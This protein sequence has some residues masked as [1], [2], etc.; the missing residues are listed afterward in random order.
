METASFDSAGPAPR[1]AAATETASRRAGAVRGGSP[2][3]GDAS[4]WD[5]FLLAFASVASSGSPPPRPD[6]QP[7]W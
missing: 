3:V 2:S 4:A 1:G 6:R 5:L 7:M